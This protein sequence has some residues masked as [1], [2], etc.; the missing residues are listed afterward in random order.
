M[1]A[2]V[3]AEIND[4]VKDEVK[5]ESKQDDDKDAEGDV[6]WAQPVHPTVELEDVGDDELAFVESMLVG[7]DE[8]EQLWPLR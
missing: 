2:G 6:D 5:D 4:D 8:E 7:D 3:K 1:N